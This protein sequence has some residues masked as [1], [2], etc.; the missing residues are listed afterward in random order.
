MDDLRTRILLVEDDPADALLVQRTLGTPSGPGFGF[1]LY[2]CQDLASALERL[3]PGE[4]DV[5]LLDLHLPDSQ[6][7]ETVSRVRERDPL[8]PIVVFTVAGAED[9]ALRSLQAGAQDYLV[10][11]ELSQSGLRRAIRYAMERQRMRLEA[12][13]L[14][15]RL[16]QAQKL[17]SLGMLAGGIAHD[18]NN[19]LTVILA[20]SSLALR[21]LPDRSPARSPLAAS[22]EAARF[23]SRLTDQLL[24]YS[25][26]ASTVLEPLDVSARISDIENLLRRLL[27]SNVSLELHLG[28]GLPGVAADAG[29]IQQLVMNLVRNAAEAVGKEE[30]RVVV[31]T[32][33]AQVDAA[34]AADVVSGTSIA[35]GPAVVMSVR[36]TGCGMDAETAERIFD[37]FFTTKFT[38]R[39]LGLAACH[40]IV[41]SHEGALR[42]ESTPG[43]GTTIRAYFPVHEVPK[44]RVPVSGGDGARLLVVDDDDGVREAARRCLEASGYRVREAD[45]GRQAIAALAQDP[46][47]VDLV[48]LDLTMPDL[49]GDE[50]FLALRRIRP[51][52][53]VL[54]SSGYDAREVSRRFDVDGVSGFLSKPY[55]PEALAAKVAALLASEPEAEADDE[56]ARAG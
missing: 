3:E 29:Q 26:G 41:R 11:G 55:E 4:I 10:K 18:F 44:R 5:V 6:G 31:E 40:G 34:T 13:R 37:P 16:R 28:E 33:L 45:G 22:I 1:R 30:G 19:L 43:G 39:G 15:E 23:A 47:A 12:E 8:V 53:R 48:L 2:R 20:N 9:L 38:G 56:S 54:L 52:L 21:D 14:Q 17:E 32:R 46:G 49:G 42:V 35:E 36:D 50:T 51:D 27:S 24:A 7:A 25:G